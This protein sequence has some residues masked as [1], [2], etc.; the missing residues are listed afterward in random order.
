MGDRG[1]CL[2]PPVAGPYA[3][4]SDPALERWKPASSA[5]FRIGPQT[6]GGSAG[7][8]GEIKQGVNFYLIYFCLL[9]ETICC[10]HVL[11]VARV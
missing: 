5:G 11:S 3:S 8:P 1:G 9:L 10:G 6:G 4:A 7:K 2:R